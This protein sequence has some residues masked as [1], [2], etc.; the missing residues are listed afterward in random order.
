MF[1]IPFS[2]MSTQRL[3]RGVLWVVVGCCLSPSA[4]ALDPFNEGLNLYNA[5]RYDAAKMHFRQALAADPA[6][7][8]GHY[9]LANT[10]L[11]LN[12]LDG[13]RLE[14]ER[15]A[16]IRSAPRNLVAQAKQAI[17][18]ID[19]MTGKAQPK[20]APQE[21]VMP[22]PH[23]SESDKSLSEI[24]R[25]LQI[26]KAAQSHMDEGYSREI[27]QRGTEDAKRIRD[28]S[29]SAND[30]SDYNWRTRWRARGAAQENIRQAEQDAQRALQDADDRANRWKANNDARNQA[31]DE[32][33]VNLRNQLSG[34]VNNGVRMDPKGTNLYVRNYCH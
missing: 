23:P 15:C 3:V 1:D 31:L 24:D 13:A 26:H 20:V 6:S 8:A 16:E 5:G 14:Y 9:C 17:E 30:L 2:K 18:R 28:E 25:Q 22:L 29:R 4:V 19:I 10:L 27:L 7:S 11:K 34:S 12:D 33:A 32:S 21:V